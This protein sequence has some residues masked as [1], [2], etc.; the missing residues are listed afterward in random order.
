L[1]PTSLDTI[2][3]NDENAVES[4]A[5]TVSVGTSIPGIP[6]RR[7]DDTDCAENPPWFCDPNNTGPSLF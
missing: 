1:P 2:I 4:T 7:P 3:N 5:F 6:L